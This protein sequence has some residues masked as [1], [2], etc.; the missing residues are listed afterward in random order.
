MARS[1]ARSW[2]ARPFADRALY[3]TLAR[4]LAGSVPFA[5]PL[6]LNRTDI[7]TVDRTGPSGRETT[8]RREPSRA[9]DL[10]LARAA[11]LTVA[12]PAR[13]PSAVRRPPGA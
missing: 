10:P 5:L 3:K 11:S 9:S 4:A 6:R 12:A 7:G 13:S 1:A 8:S 2:T